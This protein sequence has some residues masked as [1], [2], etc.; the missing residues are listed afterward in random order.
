MKIIDGKAQRYVKFLVYGCQMNIDFT[1]VDR[2]LL[3][4]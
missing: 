4:D 1:V 2:S 3:R